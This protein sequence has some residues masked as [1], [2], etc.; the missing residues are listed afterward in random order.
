MTKL[1]TL[2]S[3]VVVYLY[4]SFNVLNVKMASQSLLCYY[5]NYKDD[6]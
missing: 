1:Q 3:E 6:G 4:Y 2:R 5:I